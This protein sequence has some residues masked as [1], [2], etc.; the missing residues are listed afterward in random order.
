MRKVHIRNIT[1]DMVLARPVLLRNTVLLNQ[2]VS[3]L[4]KYIDFLE[5]IG[6]YSLYIEDSLSEGIDVPELVSEQ[7][8][9]RCRNE[10]QITFDT[11]ER[12]GALETTELASASHTILDEL[13]ERDDILISLDNIGT[14]DANTLSHS[15][16]V[17]IY[18]LLLGTKLGYPRS[19]LQILAEGAM[20]HDIGKT[21]LDQDVLFKPGKLTK[22]EFE[23]VKKHTVFGYEIL[24]ENPFISSV[25]KNIALYH[26]ERLNGEGYPE[27]ICKKNIHPFARIVAISDVYDALTMDRCY[28]KSM[29]VSKAVCI[30][31][32]DAKEK[33]DPDF[34][35]VFIK[36]LAIFPNGSF[37]KLSDG[38]VGIVK[39]QNQGQPFRPVVRILYELDGMKVIPYD[40]DLVQTLAIHIE[41]EI[42]KI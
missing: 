3:H 34:V 13:L 15:L 35:D 10:L 8:L 37:V 2:G 5:S 28:R 7:T 30:L 16:N 17:T 38:R 6:V 18:S 4:D 36:Q 12:T 24:C 1:Q 27:G 22:A 31:Q 29:P 40:M 25:A 14:T 41:K 39:S 23:H 20:L 26:H 9:I 33:L 32:E 11:F 19:K 42:E 21:V